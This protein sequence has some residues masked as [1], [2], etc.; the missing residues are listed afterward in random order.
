MTVVLELPLVRYRHFG[1]VHCPLTCLTYHVIAR[2]EL[3]YI[4]LQPILCL[5]YLRLY[6]KIGRYG[7]TREKWKTMYTP[8][9]FYRKGPPRFKLSDYTLQ[10]LLHCMNHTKQ[11]RAIYSLSPGSAYLLHK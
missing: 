9:F 2:K 3:L 4:C 10:H 7:H 5:K 8:I 6:W 11:I 1:L